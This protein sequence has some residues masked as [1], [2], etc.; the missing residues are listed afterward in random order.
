MPLLLLYIGWV[1]RLLLQHYK[2]PL[3]SV[4]HIKFDLINLV[5]GLGMNEEILV[6][7]ERIH[8]QVRTILYIINLPSRWLN[9][10]IL[11]H[12]PLPLPQQHPTVQ[13]LPQVQIRSQ[14]VRFVIIYRQGLLSQLLLR[15]LLVFHHRFVI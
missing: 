14:L 10:H 2:F 4:K 6:V 1:E 13:P 9:K 11:R 7:E 8:Q 12:I 3:H 5:F 15:P